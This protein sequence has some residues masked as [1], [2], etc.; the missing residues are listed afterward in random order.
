MELTNRSSLWLGTLLVSVVALASGCASSGL[1]SLDSSSIT[2]DELLAGAPLRVSQ[3]AEQLVAEEDVLSV[4]E[5]MREFLDS[6]VDAKANSH[7]K[8]VQLGYS[9][10]NSDAFGLKYDDRSR[11]AA[12]SFNLRSGNCLSFSNMFVAMARYVGLTAQFQEVDIPPDWGLEDETF[13]LN[14]HVNVLVDLGAFGEHVVDFNIMDFKVSYG[15]RKISD[16]RARA[17]YY[18]NKGVERMLAGDT[19]SALAFFRRAVT[20]VDH[21]FSPAWA[22]L[23]TLY[24]RKKLPDHAE[25]AYLQAM[26]VDQYNY[27]AMSNLAG[28]YQQHGELEKAAYYRGKVRFHRNRNPYYRY[29][30]A[31]DA[32]FERDYDTAVGHLKYAIRKRSKEDQFYFLLGLVYLQK[33]DEQKARRWLTKAE[34]MAATEALRRNYSNK[35]EALFSTLD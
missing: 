2:P 11:T 3:S 32:F 14:R 9:I 8:L 34:K 20:V 15:R 18:N 16:S 29:Y 24:L 21:Q 5:E 35:I 17:H 6:H 23:G 10:F 7:L 31:R 13:V 19:A 12:E 22:N 26:K 1:G 28:L 27:V 25:A 4:N 33:G 30:L